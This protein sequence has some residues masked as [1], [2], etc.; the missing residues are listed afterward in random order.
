[1][2]L[3]LFWKNHLR[4]YYWSYIVL[5]CVLVNIFR[6]ILYHQRISAVSAIFCLV[7]L[8][9]VTRLNKST[10]EYRERYDR[11]MAGLDEML[12]DLK[13]QNRRFETGDTS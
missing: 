2:K 6:F 11:Y 12:K 7:C 5:L 1:M 4:H 9:F 3:K 10:K 13:A 8:F